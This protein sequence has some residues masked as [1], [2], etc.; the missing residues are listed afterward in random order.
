MSNILGKNL[1]LTLFGESHGSKIGAVID[2]ICAGIKIDEDFIKECLSLRRP[3]MVGET[4]RVENDEFEI[5]SGVFNGYTT[6]SSLC[7]LI[8]N[9]SVNSKDYEG[10]KDKA[11]PSHA[12]YVA[13]VKY[14]GYQDYRGGGHFSGRISAAIVASGAII[15]KALQDKGI[16]ILSHIKQVGDVKDR[17]F[18]DFNED[19]LILKGL[20]FPTL[21]NVKDKMIEQINDAAKDN[22]SI[23]GCIQVGI[24]NLPVGL[25]EP[26]F[27]SLEGSLA[28]AMF[29][30]GGVKGIEFGLG[31]NFASSLGSK[32]N[33]EFVCL[34]NKV[35]TKTNNNGGINGGISN[36]MPVV[37]NVAIKPTPSI[38]KMQQTINMNTLENE[39]ILVQGRHDPC[40]VRRINI[41]IKAMCAFVVADALINLNGIN[42]LRK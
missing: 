8:N 28:N 32:A 4:K 16:K 2:G 25:G 5:V 41:V 14:D 13:N 24:V 31:F 15:L 6:G 40:I 9:S 29:S 7:I 23:G 36:G 18:N 11:R 22:D 17:D 26:W 20:S 33:D 42:A 34:N 21:D 27:N 38:G 3:S 30:I 19:E 1:T 10:I 12:D 39:N 35:L 37:F